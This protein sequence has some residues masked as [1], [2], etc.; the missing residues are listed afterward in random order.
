MISHIAHSATSVHMDKGFVSIHPHSHFKKEIL[1]I[2][3]GAVFCVKLMVI[4]E[5][6]DQSSELNPNA[7]KH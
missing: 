5:A 6:T 1:Q 7:V 2:L 4:N 3:F